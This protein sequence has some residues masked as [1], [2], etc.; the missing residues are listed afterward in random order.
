[1]NPSLRWWIGLLAVLWLAILTRLPRL[2]VRPMHADEAVLA[3]KT[4][5]LVEKG[6]FQYDPHDYHG[7]VLQ[8]LA[9]LQKFIC[10]ESLAL[11][12]TLIDDPAV[13]SEAKVAVERIERSLTFRR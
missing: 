10:A 7:P 11:A 9:A 13:G 4:G 3:D 1:M 8:Y 12:K 5:T 2:D 6:L